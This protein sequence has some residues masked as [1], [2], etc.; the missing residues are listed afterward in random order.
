MRCVYPPIWTVGALSGLL[1][2]AA[3]AAPPAK[4]QRAKPK[5]ALDLLTQDARPAPATTPATQP[6]GDADSPFGKT[7]SRPPHALPGVVIYSNGTKV[8]G[9]IW[10]P[11][12]K[13]WRIYERAG[14]QFRDV[15]FDV[16]KRIDG[17]VEWQ[18]MEDDWRWKEGGMDV[19][20]FTGKKY[21]NRMT[22]FSFTLLD[23]RKIV[24]TIAQMLF[25]ELAGHV[26]RATLHK[27]Q[28]GR[29]DQ[30]LE[31][32]PYIKTVLF[33]AQAMR[34]AVEEITTS[35]PTS[36]QAPEPNLKQKQTLTQSHQTP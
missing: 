23:D 28:Q 30:T 34:D 35:R 19:K 8:P 18:R 3:F 12:G 15:P 10:T 32:M 9:Y 11:S 24:G 17:I 1:V 20:V 26:T 14:K 25:V 21:P 27:R 33:D 6:T 4:Y 7:K 29:I 5:S 2:A 22:Y 16:V 13:E 31:T 36:R